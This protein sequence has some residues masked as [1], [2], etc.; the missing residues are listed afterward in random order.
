MNLDLTAARVEIEN[1]AI[2][3]SELVEVCLD[4]IERL[5][6]H[7]NCFVEVD[8]TAAIAAARRADSRIRSGMAL[9]AI[10]GLPVALKDNINAEGFETRNGTLYSHCFQKDAA[11]TEKLRSAGAVI[12]GKLNMDECAI[13]GT[14]DNVHFGQT[15]NPWR[16]G[17]TAGGSSGGAGAAVAGGLALAALGTDTLG[18]VRLPAAYC[19]LVGLKA[20][21]GLIPTDGVI[22]LS[23]TL[24]H[25]GPICR[26]VS[27]A[28]LLFDLL[29]AQTPTAPLQ[30]DDLKGLRIGI[31]DP[32]FTPVC[33]AEVIGAFQDS[34]SDLESAGAVI[35]QINITGPSSRDL[36][37]TALLVIEAEGWSALSGSLME[38]PEAYSDPLK[39]MLEYGRDIPAAKLEAAY[40]GI[41]ETKHKI[42]SLFAEIDF[43]VTPTTPQAAFPLTDTAP[44]NQA[45]FTGLSNIADCPALTM[46][47]GLD[48]SG[49]P[50]AI[51]FMAAPRQ[52][53]LLF[54]TAQFMENIW[55]RLNVPVLISP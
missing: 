55:G 27:D 17:Y 4:R 54:S 20:T 33:T 14:T 23:R 19:G 35:K 30:M 31:L 3:P 1:G 24:D 26:S 8:E 6:P 11:V 48:A 46:P 41:L 12:L 2:R 52:E 38:Q 9:S 15:I 47:N 32:S 10:D 50:T 37:R 7:L 25:V 49:M 28:K 44:V 53:Q 21:S 43:L 22:P 39:S 13:G 16:P 18:S 29:G 45:E 40:Q 36:R 42:V 51:Q 34:L 5:D